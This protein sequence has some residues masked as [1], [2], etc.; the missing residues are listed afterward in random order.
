MFKSGEVNPAITIMGDS[1]GKPYFTLAINAVP[2]YNFVS[3]GSG[4]TQ[5]FSRYRYTKSGDRIGN[6][7]DW[8]L[9]KFIA[10]Y[11]KK[12][13]K[14]AVGSSPN[15]SETDGVKDAIFHYVYAVLHDP[16]YR[17]I[18][19]LNLKRE[20]PRIPLY[21]DFARWAAWGETLMQIHIGYE[22]VEPWAVER[23]DMPAKRAEGT[24]PKPVLKS[25]PDKG[26]VVVDADTQISDIP[27]EAWTYRLGNRS[28]ID[29]VLDQHKEKRPRD[30][31][32]AAKFN[33]YR[34]ADYKESMIAL[35]A[36]VVRV[37]VE[38]VAI[39]EAMKALPESARGVE[40][41]EAP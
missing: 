25:H 8:A 18:Y 29:W 3:P 30:P 22:E 35:L 10:H 13:L 40:D 9:N 7:T 26:L 27:P 19:A 33:T 11:G 5:T 36:K 39:T 14:A 31:T 32:I 34:F 28:A 23:I 20:F 16:I 6:I 12:A 37:S 17:E 38:T 2:D 1:T 41:A 15:E 4:G 21:A 24:H